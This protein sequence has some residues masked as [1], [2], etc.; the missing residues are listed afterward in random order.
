MLLREQLLL[1]VSC[2]KELFGG[3]DGRPSSDSWG[4]G[5]TIGEHGMTIVW[6]AVPVA[7][8]WV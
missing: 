8:A 3:G 5:S 2:L 6:T 7:V 4:G 1:E